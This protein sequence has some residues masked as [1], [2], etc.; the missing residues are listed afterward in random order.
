MRSSLSILYY[1]VAVSYTHLDVYKRQDQGRN[2]LNQLLQMALLFDKSELQC[3]AYLVAALCLHDA[4]FFRHD[5]GCTQGGEHGLQ[6]KVG[7]VILLREMAPVSYTHLDVYKRQ[8][9]VFSLRGVGSGIS[10]AL[11]PVRLE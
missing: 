6:G 4:V 7:R 5:T 11:V 2:P 1:I 10:A 3:R 8:R 9:S